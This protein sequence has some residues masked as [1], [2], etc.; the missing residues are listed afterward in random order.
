LKYWCLR[1]FVVVA[2]AVSDLEND[3]LHRKLALYWSLGIANPVEF[4]W[5]QFLQ[6]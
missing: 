3:V 4:L 6:G 2:P 5:K 1:R